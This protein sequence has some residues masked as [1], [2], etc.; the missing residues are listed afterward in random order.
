MLFEVA[1]EN[2]WGIDF[3]DDFTDKDAPR[4][5]LRGLRFRMA[6]R[7]EQRSKF[8]LQPCEAPWLSRRAQL[9]Q[10]PTKVEILFVGLGPSCLRFRPPLSPR[11]YLIPIMEPIQ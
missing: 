5:D 1:F 2:G 9:E 3:S 11:T 10:S 4:F 8:G 6:S 7:F